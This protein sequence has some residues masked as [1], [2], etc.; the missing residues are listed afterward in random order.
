MTDDIFCAVKIHSYIYYQGANI[1]FEVWHHD[2]VSIR[3]P[4][5]IVDILEYNFTGFIDGET[6]PVTVRGQRVNS[7]KTRYLYLDSLIF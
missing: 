3:N 6:R 1:R 7:P 2:T 5:K 4:Y